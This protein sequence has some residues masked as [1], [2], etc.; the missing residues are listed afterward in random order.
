MLCGVVKSSRDLRRE[1][2]ARE[3]TE[4]L[5]AEQREREQ[6]ARRALVRARQIATIC[7]L[8][9][10][11]AVAAA[12][13]AFVS[14]QRARRAEQQAEHART[15]AQQAR[16][17][18]EQLLA[19]LTDDFVRE[20]ES[21][22]RLNVVAEFAK[23]QI[24]YFHSLPAALKD[25]E[26]T[27][28]GALAMVHYARVMRQLGNLDAAAINAD[29]AVQLLEQLR[30]SGDASEATTIA[31]AQSYAMQGAIL[32]NKN[33]AAGAVASKRSADI[34]RPV[35]EAPNASVAARR[36]YVGVLSRRG[37]EQ[38]TNNENEDAVRTEQQTMQL[39]T[40]LGAR[41]L[42]SIDMGAM[43]ADAASW[44]TSALSNLGRNDEARRVG[45]DADALA[46]KVLEQRPGYRLA[47]HA[48]QVIE[49]ALNGVA[50]NDLNPQ[51]ALQFARRGIQTSVTLLNFDPNSNVS[52]NNLGVAY[53]GEG[54]ALWAVGQLRE[55]LPYYVKSLDSFAKAT[56]GGAAQFVL[57]SLQMNTLENPQARLGDFA[58]ATATVAMAAPYFAKLRQREPKGSLVVAL[59]ESMTNSGEADVALEHDDAMTARRVAWEALNQMRATTAKGGFQELQRYVAL[60]WA[61]DIAGHAEYVLG[62]FAAAEKAERVAVEARK[63]YLTEAV[64]DRRDVAEKSTWL[65]MALARQGHLDEA[66]QVIDPVV[67]FHRELAAKNHGDRWQTLELASALY[68]DALADPKKSAPLLREAAA[69]IDG[70]PPTIRDV[71]DVRLWRDRIRQAQLG[72][73]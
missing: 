65:A 73:G 69:L 26:S 21:F 52:A 72:A 48:K 32:D 6:S 66:V 56:A 12:G 14:S 9:A 55:A 51:E 16:G 41:D 5:L 7:V 39:A 46:D 33:D 61:A 8:L 13:F 25:A 28:N 20:L 30:Q 36:A 23:R 70:L 10:I 17:Q 15:E 31:L 38:L 34:L 40:A 29:E 59:F 18:A 71:H 3:A 64:S 1:R 67:K 27:R 50:Q 60:Y 57:Y 43:Y 11:G 53:Q 24:D 4:R 35:A 37:Y 58:A 54:D 62:N 49:T 22:G 47:L 45:E 2:E 42:S 19:Y 68:A 63:K 44:Q